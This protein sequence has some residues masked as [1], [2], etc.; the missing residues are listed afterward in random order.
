MRALT[1]ILWYHHPHS[2]ENYPQ[3]RQDPGTEG[4]DWQVMGRFLHQDLEL[5]AEPSLEEML[6]EPIVQLIMRRDGVEAVDMRGVI[7]RV[8]RQ[9]TML[10]SA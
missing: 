5:G 8:K 4:W 7:D 1:E 6:A 3:K 10:L 2:L 9:Y